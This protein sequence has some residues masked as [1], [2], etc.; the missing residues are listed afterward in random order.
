M[1]VNVIN[2]FYQNIVGS[3]KNAALTLRVHM[4]IINN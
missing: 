1:T 2:L 3:C 4:K